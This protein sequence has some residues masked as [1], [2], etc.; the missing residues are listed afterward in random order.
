MLKL[1][2]VRLCMWHK[3]Q[4]QGHCSGDLRAIGEIMYGVAGCRTAELWWLQDGKVGYQNVADWRWGWF[5]PMF[6]SNIIRFFN[7]VG[8]F[9]GKRAVLKLVCNVHSVFK[10]RCLWWCQWSVVH[11]YNRSLIVVRAVVWVVY[12]TRSCSVFLYVGS[13]TCCDVYYASLLILWS[14]RRIVYVIVCHVEWGNG[15]ISGGSYRLT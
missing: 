7:R 12:I 10:V 8:C 1:L 5:M 4:N 6:K 9:V 3:C 14:C 15:V 11:N 2:Y 13:T